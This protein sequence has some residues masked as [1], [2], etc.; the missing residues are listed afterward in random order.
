MLTPNIESWERSTEVPKRMIANAATRTESCGGSGK[1]RRTGRPRV[2]TGKCRIES[3]KVVEM[4]E[5]L[6]YKEGIWNAM[7]TVQKSKVICLHRRLVRRS[8][9][10][11]TTS[12]TNVPMSDVSDSITRLT[13]AIESLE[14]SREGDGH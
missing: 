3:G 4:L 8:V 13:R 1:R 5:G 9:Q 6:H 10:V 2:T 7:T 14:T 11:A 12:G